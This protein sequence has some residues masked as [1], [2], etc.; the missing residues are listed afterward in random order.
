MSRLTAGLIG[1]VF[2]LILV[3]LFPGRSAID[4]ARFP[5]ATPQDHYVCERNATDAGNRLMDI[6]PLWRWALGIRS[7]GELY[8]DCMA[9]KGYAK[10]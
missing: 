2:L 1:L 10:R 7:T 9:A 4:R 3:L 8:D 5:T 6:S